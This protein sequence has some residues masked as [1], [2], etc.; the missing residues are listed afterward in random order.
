MNTDTSNIREGASPGVLHGGAALLVAQLAA[1]RQREVL[2]GLEARVARVRAQ[3]RRLALALQRV[4]A[5]ARRRVGEPA[6][7]ED[8]LE[9]YYLEL[10]FSN[11]FIDRRYQYLHLAGCDC[12]KSDEHSFIFHLKVTNDVID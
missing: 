9:G 4:Q 5:Q 11:H 2:R 12:Q 7:T 3:R 10:D 6:P 8:R 1:Q